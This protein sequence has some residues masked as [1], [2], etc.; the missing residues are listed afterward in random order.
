[1]IKEEENNDPNI[2][3]FIQDTNIENDSNA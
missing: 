2:Q 3:N 1:V